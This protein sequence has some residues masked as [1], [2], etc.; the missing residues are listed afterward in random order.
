[1]RKQIRPDEPLVLRANAK[2]WNEQWRGL[3][4][5]NPSAKFS[6]YQI[7]GR[8]VRDLILPTLREMN[9]S[10][11]SFCDA[12]PLEDRSSEPVE[13]FRPKSNPL[14]YD[15]AY[16]W[17]NLY[18]CCERC[19]KQKK[20]YWHETLLAPDATEYTFS[21]YFIF[22]FLTGEIRENPVVSVED[23]ERAKVTIALFGLDS[24]ARRRF[25]RLELKK[26]LESEQ[27]NLDDWAY[28]DF[29]SP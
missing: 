29:L 12:F 13:H 23:Q 21:N 3:R 15:Q 28:R 6:W 1:M 9:Q 10:H 26:W 17:T 18:Y 19:Q 25:R 11:C 7:D 14:F 16:A 8:S 5:K 24:D 20:E 27:L 4:G 22:D 2:K